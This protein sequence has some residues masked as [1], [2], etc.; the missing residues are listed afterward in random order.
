MRAGRSARA[1]T[2]P[3]STETSPDCRPCV[4]RGRSAAKLR[5]GLA[6]PSID[7]RR[8]RRTG[9]RQE[10]FG[11]TEPRRQACESPLGLLK[12][13]RAGRC[14][15]RL[16]ARRQWCDSDVTHSQGRALQSVILRCPHSRRSLRKLGCVRASKDARPRCCNCRAVV[17]RGS[18]SLAP[19]DDG[20]RNA[21]AATT[22]GPLIPCKPP[23][24]PFAAPAESARLTVVAGT[25]AV[26]AALAA[27]AV[28]MRSPDDNDDCSSA[29]R[30]CPP[31][32]GA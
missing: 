19:Q 23:F 30:P 10:R 15:R 2:M 5:A 24:W 32:T 22:R 8:S 13:I 11:A 3:E 6:T 9:R 28:F 31:R 27:A 7:C 29:N 26:S 4:M 25:L 18:L 14:P 17:L 1:H 20:E 12:P 16:T 21:L